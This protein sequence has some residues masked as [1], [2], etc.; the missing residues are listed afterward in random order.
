MTDASGPATPAPSTVRNLRALWAVA[1]PT[2]RLQLY[3]TLVLM[4]LG[5]VAEL[6]TIGAVLPLLA[7]AAEPGYAENIPALK[8]VL[9]AVAGLLGVNLIVAAAALL[10]GNALGATV[11]RLMLGWVTQKFVFGLHH[12]I[13]MRVFQRSVRQPYEYHVRQNSS[14][15][16]AALEKIYMIVAGVLGPGVQAITSAGIAFCIAAFLF[17]IDPLAAVVGGGSI[18]LLYIAISMLSHRTLSRV[19]KGLSQVRPRRIKTVQESLGGMRDIILDHSQ[20]VFERKRNAEEDRMRR[21]L[22]L[23][24]FIALAPRLV[25][26]G[27]AILLIALMAVWFSLQPGGML[28]AIPVL[29]A[30]ALGAQRLLPLIQTVYLGWS[31]CAVHAHNINDIVLLMN[32][33]ERSAPALP[34]GQAVEPFGDAI[35]LRGLAFCYAPDAPA[36]KRVD[37][38]IR[39]GER[40]GLIGKTGSGK[41][42]LVDLLMGLLPPTEGEILLGGRRLGDDNMA[43]WQAQLA[44]VP[45]AIFLSDDSIAANIAFGCG[46]D[47]IDMD[48]VR[49]AAERA[50]VREFVDQLPEG[51]ATEVGERGVRLSG[52]QL[53]RIGIARALYK[54]ATVLILDEATSALDED[55]EAAIMDAVRRLDRDLTI[56]LIAHRLSTVA[57]C[58][59]V[60]RLEG[61]EIVQSGS[62][63]EVVLRRA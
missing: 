57:T 58:D 38:V 50:E 12:D 47:E 1:G 60:Y 27:A 6:L 39:K 24:H 8:A 37:L 52:G 10:V 46:A 30:L 36:L 17:V 7:L 11:L 32:R 51:F 31:G 22:I 26:E 21:L 45:Q 4:V 34:D 16:L 44:H 55:T 29:G 59:T 48:R 62:F 23:H 9:D 41:S 40:V 19:S 15:V 2:R 63:E 25:V 42:T 43:N 5:A 33:P 49:E 54:R 18:G 13:N 61:G 20:P 3:V 14:E 35:E 28:A 56:I 53:Q